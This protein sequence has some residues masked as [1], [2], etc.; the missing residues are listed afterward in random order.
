MAFCS[1]ID[2]FDIRISELELNFQFILV[3]FEVLHEIKMRIFTQVQGK[4][5]H[6]SRQITKTSNDG[7]KRK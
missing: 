4:W 1:Q 2:N 5:H 7:A 3:F 6:C